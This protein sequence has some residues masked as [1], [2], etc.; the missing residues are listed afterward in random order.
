MKAIGIACTAILLALSAAALRAD[1]PNPEV[2]KIIQDIAARRAE[3]EEQRVKQLEAW[4]KSE[5]RERVWSGSPPP[6]R[7]E[8]KK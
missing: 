8:P 7:N 5:A 6:P 3:K 1:D 2:A 4:A